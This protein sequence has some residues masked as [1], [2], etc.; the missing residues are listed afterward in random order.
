MQK[1]LWHCADLSLVSSEVTTVSRRGAGVASITQLR[2]SMAR[3]ATTWTVIIIIIIIIIIIMIT[4]ARRLSRGGVRGP[5]QQHTRGTHL[6]L[7]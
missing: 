2:L 7:G 1:L 3:C 6:K 5:Q 4:W